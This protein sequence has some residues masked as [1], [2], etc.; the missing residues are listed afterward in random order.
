[1]V[2]TLCTFSGDFPAHRVHTNSPDL[3]LHEIFEV[4]PVATLRHGF[5]PIRIL[6]DIGGVLFFSIHQMYQRLDRSTLLDPLKTRF[7][8]RQVLE[9]R[10][11]NPIAPALAISTASWRQQDFERFFEIEDAS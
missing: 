8:I 2:S 6:T 5:L 3:A 10:I 7:Q 1:M 4:E 9:L 11:I